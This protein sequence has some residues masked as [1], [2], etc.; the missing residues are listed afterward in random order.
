MFICTCATSA[1]GSASNGNGPQAEQAIMIANAHRGTPIHMLWTREED[2]VGTTYRAMGVARLKAGLDAEGWPIALEVRTGMQRDGF[3][4]EASFDVIS[5]YHVPN[6][7]YSSHTTKFHV[8]G[9][10]RSVSRLKRERAHYLRI[11]TAMRRR[12]RTKR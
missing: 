11:A 5:R 7:R 9:E 10:W 3:G 6:Y 4:P 2:F 1:A 8:P 12:A